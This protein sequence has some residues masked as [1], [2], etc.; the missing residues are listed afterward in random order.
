MPGTWERL[1]NLIGT[2]MSALFF[3]ASAAP[4]LAQGHDTAHSQ[5]LTAT[6][7]DYQRYEAERRRQERAQ[8]E[9]ERREQERLRLENEKLRQENELREQERLR[10]ENERLRQ[11]IELAK[12]EK[13]RLEAEAQERERA[14]AVASRGPSESTDQG[15]DAETYEQLRKIGQ[16]YDEGI[17]TDE[18]FQRLKSKIL[19]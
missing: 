19:D 14:Q 18:E 4:V 16:L 5:E 7:E 17:L 2:I 3:M 1:R 6:A 11:E 8:Q 15:I 10:L 12:Q 9:R 13:L